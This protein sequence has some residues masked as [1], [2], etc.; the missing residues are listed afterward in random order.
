[1]L[2]DMF[3]IYWFF[4]N[5]ENILNLIHEFRFKLHGPR[6]TFGRLAYNRNYR[7]ADFVFRWIGLLGGRGSL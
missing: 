4:T 6:L 3:F 5:L 1:M 2:N 7:V